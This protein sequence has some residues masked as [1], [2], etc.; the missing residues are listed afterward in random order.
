M[1]AKPAAGDGKERRQ[2]GFCPI[3]ATRSRPPGR[4]NVWQAWRP[5]FGLGRSRVP[6]P[7]DLFRF[8]ARLG[9]F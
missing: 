1:D 4:R 6:L 5:R 2:R 7:C 3:F 8:P 9:P